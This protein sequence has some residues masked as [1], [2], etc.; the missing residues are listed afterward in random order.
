MVNLVEQ[1]DKSRCVFESQW[2][3]DALEFNFK[4]HLVS[5]KCLDASSSTKIFF[6]KKQQMK[7]FRDTFLDFSNIGSIRNKRQGSVV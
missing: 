1:H 4:S 3:N 7:K 6:L 2:R 5:K